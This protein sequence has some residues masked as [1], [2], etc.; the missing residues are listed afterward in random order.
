[1]RR[2]G[3]AHAASQID[4]EARARRESEAK[5]AAVRLSSRCRIACGNNCDF[6]Y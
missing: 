5:A 2:L 3:S 4:D 6:L 1:V